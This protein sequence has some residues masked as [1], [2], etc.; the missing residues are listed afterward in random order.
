MVSY[1]A[2]YLGKM[3]LSLRCFHKTEFLNILIIPTGVLI[4]SPFFSMVV[5]IFCFHGFSTKKDFFLR[6]IF[7]IQSYRNQKK[8]R[9]N[10]IR[11]SEDF[12]FQWLSFHRTFLLT[13]FR[14]SFPK[15]FFN[16]LFWRLPEEGGGI[17][18]W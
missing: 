9:K 5:N 15:T 3:R 6:G 4:S 10:N 12:L 17:I 11:I 1:R 8:S 18:F 16:E 7:C 2:W 14:I 13:K